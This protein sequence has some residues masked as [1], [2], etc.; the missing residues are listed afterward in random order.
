MQAVLTDRN[1]DPNKLLADAETK[2]DAI[3]AQDR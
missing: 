2:V 3:F 1:A